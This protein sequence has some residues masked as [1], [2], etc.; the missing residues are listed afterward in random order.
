[1][2]LP[3]G[4]TR[5]LSREDR[6]PSDDF[7]IVW[8]G[9]PER[10]TDGESMPRGLKSGEGA[11]AGSAG[12]GAG[13][14]R[15]FAVAVDATPLE[16]EG[17]VESGNLTWRTLISGDRTPSNE[18]SVGVAHWPPHGR[19]LAHRHEPAE[20]Y[21]GLTGEGTVIADEVTLRIAPGV[22]VYI[23]GNTEH[24]V[25]AGPQG[26][27]IVYGFARDSYGD[28]VYHMSPPRA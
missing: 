21:F 20:F 8:P 15:A 26:L 1:M 28:I 12:R 6:A 16:G 17:D 24:T 9:A 22:A 25:I 7:A 11:E 23:P 10:E 19:L 27:S 13:G 18:L 3:I 5:S 4:G 14:P 2:K